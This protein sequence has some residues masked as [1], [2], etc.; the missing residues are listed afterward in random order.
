MQIRVIL[1]DL[2]LWRNSSSAIKI[3]TFCGAWSSSTKWNCRAHDQ[4]CHFDITNNSPSCN[5]TL[6]RVYYN[7][8]MVFA[9]NCA[10]EGINNL[11]INWNNETPNMQFSNVKTVNVQLE[12]YHTFGCQVYILDSRSKTN[13]KGVP[14]LEPQSLLCIH[15]GHLLTCAGSVAIVLNLKTGLVLSQFQIVRNDQF[16]KVSQICDL[17]VPLNWAKIVVNS[18]KLVTT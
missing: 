7:R 5:T 15:V 11:I 2:L 12:Y 3:L 10:K 4:R 13:L 16:T 14:K 17:I 18:S 8:F 1:Q 6:A 9:A